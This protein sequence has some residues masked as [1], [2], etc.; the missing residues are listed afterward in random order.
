VWNHTFNDALVK[1]FGFHHVSNEQCLYIRRS[2]DGSRFAIASIHVDDTFA[3]GLSEEELD[4]LQHDL[5]RKWQISVA[6]GSFILGI[7]IQRDRAHKLVHL[8]QTA[9]ID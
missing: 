9:L 7:H 5:E 3:I 2:E 1:E 8:S 6:D 4:R